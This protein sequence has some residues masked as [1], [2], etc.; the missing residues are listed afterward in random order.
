MKFI[1]DLSAFDPKRLSAV[2]ELD[3]KEKRVAVQVLRNQQQF[4]ELFSKYLDEKNLLRSFDVVS[5]MNREMTAA[6]YD[7]LWLPSAEDAWVEWTFARR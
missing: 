4:S 2:V 6:G 3:V 5:E 7:V 1:D